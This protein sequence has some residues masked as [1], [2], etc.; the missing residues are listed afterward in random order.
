M[1]NL[2]LGIQISIILNIT[3]NDTMQT[4][5]LINEGDIM[6]NYKISASSPINGT[7]LGCE[8]SVSIRID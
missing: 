3:A 7:R 5:I 6:P 8:T 2:E 1:G 4:F